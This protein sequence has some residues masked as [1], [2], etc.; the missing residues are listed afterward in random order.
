MGK[1]WSVEELTHVQP[2]LAPDVTSRYDVEV[3][4]LE[5]V[6]VPAG[7]F[8]CFKIQYTKVS[9]AGTAIENPTEGASWWSVNHDFLLVRQQDSS[10][11]AQT[12]IFE[13]VS[14]AQ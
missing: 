10:S 11:W 2:L 7:I 8:R 3:V 5:E 1:K 9:S 14:C 4:A 12:E 6:T 13:L